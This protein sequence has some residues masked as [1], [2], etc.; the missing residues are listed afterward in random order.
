MSLAPTRRE[1][2]RATLLIAMSACC[3]GSISPLSLIALKSGVALPG[4]QAWRYVTTSVLLFLY[5][6]WRPSPVHP[7]AARAT[8]LNAAPWY[9]PRVLLLAGGGQATVATLALMSLRWIPASTSAFLF[10]TYPAWV[11]IMTAV[12]GVEP[13]GAPRVAALELSWGGIAA[14]VGTPTASTLNPLGVLV[15]LLAALVYA[16]YIPVLSALQRTRTPLDVARAI[17]VGGAILFLTWALATGTLFAHHDMRSLTASI[18]QGVLSAGAFVGFLA[19][20]SQL[21]AVRAAIT[22]TIEPFWTTLLGLMLLGQPLARGTLVGGVAIM[23]A[24]LLLQRPNV[25]PRWL[26]SSSVRDDD[27][28]GRPTL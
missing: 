3:F 2:I 8:G 4:I 26:R 19:G 24:V 23:V 25:A 1:V 27:R 9:S 12:R 16:G 17:S 21:G 20:L 28:A 22:S 18:G 5:A 10:Y 11:A 13:L 6:A 14:M 15:S 7:A